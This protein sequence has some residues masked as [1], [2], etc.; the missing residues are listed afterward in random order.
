M[1]TE[2]APRKRASLSERRRADTAKLILDAVA[3]CLQNTSLGEVNLSLIAQEAGVGER[4]LYRYFPTR[5]AL[6]DAFWKGHLEWGPYPRDLRSLLAAPQRLFSKFDEQPAVTRSLV[7]S[8]QG[9]AI[10][11][12]A[13]KERVSAFRSAVREAVGDLPQAQ[14][15]RLCA[16]VQALLSAA[17]WLQ[18]R[19]FWGLDGFESGQAVA[20]AIGTLLNARKTRKVGR[21]R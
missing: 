2:R 20:E 4:T 13:N 8:V 3:R 10:A 19:E 21:A 5:D 11:L 17:T 16:S 18:M 6:F 7:R 15:T 12:S 9:H 14:F 1:S